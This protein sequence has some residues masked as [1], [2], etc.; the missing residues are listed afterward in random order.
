MTTA[1]PVTYTT[2]APTTSVVYTSAPAA[3][4]TYAAPQYITAEPAP[5]APPQ[6]LTTGMPDPKSIEK[7]KAAYAK[8]LEDQL[9]QGK[10]VLDGQL[11]YQKEYL[12]AQAEQQ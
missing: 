7:Q 8:M 9:K 1:G 3:T 5:P 12:A 6:P 11:K 2:A 10:S 4:T